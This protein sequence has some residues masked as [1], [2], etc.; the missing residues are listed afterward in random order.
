MQNT[1]ISLS[2]MTF[3]TFSHMKPIKLKRSSS[4]LGITLKTNNGKKD[5]KNSLLKDWLL[6]KVF[7]IS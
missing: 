5:N 4:T 2:C 7:K 6:I 3:N 1:K